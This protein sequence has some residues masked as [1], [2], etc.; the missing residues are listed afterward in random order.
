VLTFAGLLLITLL[1]LDG[2]FLLRDYYARG[3][4]AGA[5]TTLPLAALILGAILGATAV[6]LAIAGAFYITSAIGVTIG[7]HRLLTHRSFDA[8][9]WLRAA[10]AIAGSLAVQGAVVSWVADHRRHHAYSDQ[11]GD[12]HSPVAGFWHAHVGWLL[13]STRSDRE[14]FAPDLENDPIMRKIDRLAPLWIALSLLMPFTLG[15]LI[16][17]TWRGAL[18]GLAWGGGA[19]MFLLHHVT[20]SINSIAHTFGRRP[21][22]TKDRSRNFWPLSILS[23][24]EAWHN[25]HHAFPT[26]AYHGLRF[27]QIDPSGLVIR[28][29]AK[30]GIISNVRRPSAKQ[31]A[32][33]VITD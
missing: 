17:G 18:T 13:G 33:R 31:L 29:M 22:E 8:P 16:T 2:Y 23:L 10:F 28:L 14:H 4:W 21:Y 3:W 30:V 9:T 12:P 32:S 6:D 5:L 11:D 15:G 20:W 25:N 7:Y 1:A 19:R 26:S 24:G 27:W